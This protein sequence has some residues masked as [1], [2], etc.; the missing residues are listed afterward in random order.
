MQVP[1]AQPIVRVL[2]LSDSVYERRWARILVRLTGTVA[3]GWRRLVGGRHSGKD[4]H[5]PA[6]MTP[7]LSHVWFPLNMMQ[8]LNFDC[9][10][11]RLRCFSMVGWRG[12]N[13]LSP[14]HLCIA[15]EDGVHCTECYCRLLIKVP[16]LESREKFHVLKGCLLS[17][18]PNWSD[19]PTL[20][21]SI[22]WSSI[23]SFN[24]TTQWMWMSIL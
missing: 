20:M 4:S 18:P 13:K 3:L 16:D 17:F 23:V 24:I 22:M 11:V 12:A 5:W 6:D 1:D 21:T 7:Q 15:P 10:V 14:A 9:K 8:K 19:N 2:W